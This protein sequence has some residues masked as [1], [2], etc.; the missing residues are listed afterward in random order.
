MYRLNF[1]TENLRR[2]FN[3]E[4]LYD[5][6]K[7]AMFA[8]IHGEPVFN[9]DGTKMTDREADSMIRNVMFDVLNVESGCSPRTFHRALQDH[10]KE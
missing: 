4:G 2:V 5:Q 3:T 6:V 1:A 7:T 8:R 10:G 9:A